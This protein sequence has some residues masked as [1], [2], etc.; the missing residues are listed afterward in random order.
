MNSRLT[1]AL[2]FAGIENGAETCVGGL[3]LSV[4]LVTW[5]E[6]SKVRKSARAIIRL[7]KGDIIVLTCSDEREKGFGLGNY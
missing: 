6:T 3:I 5:G 7:T 1:T 4:A 2:P